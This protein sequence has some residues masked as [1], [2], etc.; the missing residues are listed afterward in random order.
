[1]ASTITWYDMCNRTLRQMG[2]VEFASTSDFNSASGFHSSVKDCINYSIAR[3]YDEEDSTWPFQLITT[4][5]TTLTNGTVDY[6]PVAAT[7]ASVDSIEWDSFCILRDTLLTS[8]DYQKLTYVPWPTYRDMYRPQDKN[9][10]SST[11]YGKP[12][13]VSRQLDNSISISPPA[14]EAYTVQYQY[15]GGF[16]PLS[17]YNDVSLIPDRYVQVIVD[18]ALKR[19]YDFRDNVEQAA[20]KDKEFT[21]GVN[22]MRRKLIPQAESATFL[23]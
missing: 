18:G 9:I 23:Y 19:A 22:R 20:S 12:R 10:T 5:F 6:T 14:A 13:L 17:V 16:V 3:I 8:P 21:D 15:Y 11:G 2:E 4:T 1:M 7:S